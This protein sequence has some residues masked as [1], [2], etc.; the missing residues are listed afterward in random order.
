MTET[1]RLADIE[2]IKQV[3]SRYWRGADGG[4]NQLMRDCF[5]EDCV[6]DYTDCFKDPQTGVDFLSTYSHVIRGLANWPTASLK[7]VGI[8]SSHQGHQAEIEITS[9][10]TAKA[11]FAMTD[12]L[13]FP[14][15]SP[16]AKL[17]GYGQ[18]HETY[19]KQGGAWKIKTLLL[20]RYKVEGVRS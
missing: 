11:I 17:T 20:T 4:D 2:A 5:T 15:G 8:A 12:R 16:V 3:K 14:E 18:Y 19:E 6:L 10:T 9:P 1:G 7:D 13:W